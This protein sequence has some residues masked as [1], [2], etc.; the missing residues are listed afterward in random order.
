MAIAK[1]R[2]SRRTFEDGPLGKLS[3]DELFAQARLA[4]GHLPPPRRRRLIARIVR[5][6]VLARLS[7]A[8]AVGG[9]R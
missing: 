2:H 8:P 9:A 1:S 7:R 5:Q 4:Y 3:L 6:H